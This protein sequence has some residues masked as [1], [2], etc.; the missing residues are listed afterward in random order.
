MP[1]RKHQRPARLAQWLLRMM[2]EFQEMYLIAGDL[3]EAFH[4]IISE[5]GV[6]FARIWLWGQIFACLQKYILK[7]A[8]WRI[9]MFKNNIKIF[10]NFQNRFLGRLMCIHT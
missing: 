2:R 9:I 10:K 5:R 8:I 7:A 3:E 4:Q 1:Y 6:T